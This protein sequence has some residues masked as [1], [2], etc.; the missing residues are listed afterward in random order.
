MR[1]S[2]ISHM[3]PSIE[4]RLQKLLLKQG[5]EQCG[6]FMVGILCYVGINLDGP[7]PFWFLGHGLIGNPMSMSSSLT[8]ITYQQ[9]FDC[10]SFLGLGAQWVQ[11]LS[12][13]SSM[14]ASLS[15]HFLASRYIKCGLIFFNS[16]TPY[17]FSA[18]ILGCLYVGILV[19]LY[20][21]VVFT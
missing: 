8:T 11:S 20:V 13:H 3:L 14:A 15:P 4:Q 17:G 12:S 5:M 7:W 6:I 1:P 10:W 9:W 18:P 21:Q 19:H 16:P 2:I